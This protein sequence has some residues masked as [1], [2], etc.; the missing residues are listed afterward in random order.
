MGF[1]A[2]FMSLRALLLSLA[3]AK[4]DWICCFWTGLNWKRKNARVCVD[5]FGNA[6]CSVHNKTF[7]G[8]ATASSLPASSLMSHWEPTA[9]V[10]KAGICSVSC[11]VVLCHLVEVWR[12][13]CCRRQVNTPLS[14]PSSLRCRKGIN[15]RIDLNETGI[16]GHKNTNKGEIMAL[17][18]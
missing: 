18:P 17:C 8:G 13:G 16:L 2:M 14:S 7:Q 12:Y 1:A 15:Y 4:A 5:F 11:E 3:A 6:M 9:T 10:C